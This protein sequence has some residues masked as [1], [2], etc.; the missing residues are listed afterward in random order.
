MVDAPSPVWPQRQ[1]SRR[2]LE[3]VGTT[4][5][6]AGR[7]PASAHVGTD[8]EMMEGGLLAFP[9]SEGQPKSA[10]EERCGQC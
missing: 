8:G 4:R 1:D 3:T 9:V 10:G 7:C 5:S 2:A 6:S